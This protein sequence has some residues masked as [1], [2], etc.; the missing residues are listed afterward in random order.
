MPVDKSVLFAFANV[1]AAATD[2]SIIA[3][4]A[5]AKIRVLGMLI[6]PASATPPASV[7]LNSKP[8]GAGTA[9]TAAIGLAAGVPIDA[10]AASGMGYCQTARGEGL[11]ATTGAGTNG[12]GITVAYSFVHG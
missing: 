2:T 12:V 9:I 5:N 7:T 3:A 1:A 10:G 4:N 8:A 6:T 11:T